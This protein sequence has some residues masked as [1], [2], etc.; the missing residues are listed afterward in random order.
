MHYQYRVLQRRN[1]TRT[2][3]EW[4]MS[5][6]EEL[7]KISSVEISIGEHWLDVF[8][9]NENSNSLLILTLRKLKLPFYCDKYGLD[10]IAV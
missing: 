9:N 8:T 6:T 1:D 2:F 4:K 7:Q 10:V 3:N 5:L